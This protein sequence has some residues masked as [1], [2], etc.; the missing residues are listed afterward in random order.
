MRLLIM[1]LSAEHWRAIIILVSVAVAE[2]FDRFMVVCVVWQAN[3]T[4]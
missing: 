3:L 1:F 2:G 4:L